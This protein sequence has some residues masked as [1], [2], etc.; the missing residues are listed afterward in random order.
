[1]KK[2]K[3]THFLDSIIW[4]ALFI[5]FSIVV[6]KVDV[7]PIGPLGSEVGLAAINKLVAEIL[8]YRPLFNEVAKL[9]GLVAFGWGC[10]FAVIG[11]VQL[12]RSRGFRGVDYRILLLGGLYLDLGII[13]LFFEK[14]VINYRPV[15]IDAAVGLEASYPSSHTLLTVVILMTAPLQYEYLIRNK[16]IKKVLAVICCG[17]AFLCVLTRLISGVHWFTDIVASLIL[18]IALICLYMDSVKFVQDLRK[19]GKN[20]SK[21]ANE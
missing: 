12:I 14:F 1:M 6:S 21:E 10:I 19:N 2:K 9:M 16:S 3:N 11:A 15:I 20:K 7:K 4:F 8:P 17:F 13:Y 18:S 5:V